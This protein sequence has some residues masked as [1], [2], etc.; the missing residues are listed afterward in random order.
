MLSFILIGKLRAMARAEQAVSPTW[1]STLTASVLLL[2]IFGRI[3]VIQ[4]QAELS[5][6]TPAQLK[7][8]VFFLDG[9]T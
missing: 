3:T 4:Q 5:A 1:R 8:L 9:Q 6:C 7:C 2:S